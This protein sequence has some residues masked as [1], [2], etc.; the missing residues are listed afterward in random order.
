MRDGTLLLGP[1]LFQDFEVPGSIVWGGA[2]RLV[3]HRLAGGDR[4]I[5]ALGRDDADISWSGVFTGENAVTRAQLLDTLR[6]AGG[7]LSLSWSTFFFSV[8]IVRF[9]AKYERENWIPYRIVCTVLQDDA[10][11]LASAVLGLAD[12]AL[13]DLAS[14][15]G[16]GT[17]VDLTA[18]TAA[19]AVSGAA[20]AGTAA[21]GAASAAL[22]TATSAISGGIANGGAA[23]LGAADPGAAADAAGTLAGLAGAQAYVQRAAANL[24]NA[25]S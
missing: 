18:A 21:Y 12:S 4:V 6:A 10:A 22:A 24:A 9:S 15:A 2:Q 3:V 19:L 8:V 7:V 17:S 16:F 11:A 14:A 1:V 25:S 5:D 13:T 23:L 20:T